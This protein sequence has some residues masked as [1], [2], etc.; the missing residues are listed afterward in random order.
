M[1]TIELN[2]EVARKFITT[3]YP[4]VSN[5]PFDEFAIMF[6]VS[7]LSTEEQMKELEKLNKATIDKMK[8]M[9]YTAIYKTVSEVYAEVILNDKNGIVVSAEITPDGIKIAHSMGDEK[10]DNALLVVCLDILR[11]VCYQLSLPV[12]EKEIDEVREKKS[13]SSAY[14]PSSSKKYIYRTRYRFKSIAEPSSRKPIT[15][16]TSC[17]GVMGHIRRFRDENGNVIK[18]TWVKPYTKGKGVPKENTYKITRL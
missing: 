4:E 11:G 14:V 18:E 7:A 13:Q 5:I 17:W 3:E 10:Y 8:K 2:R 12:V 9:M 1:N 16:K 15:R 6:P